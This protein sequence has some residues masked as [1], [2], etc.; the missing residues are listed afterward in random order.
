M[1]DTTHISDFETTAS[2]GETER[3]L[4]LVALENFHSKSKLKFFIRKQNPSCSKPEGSASYVTGLWLRM[5]AV[6]WPLRWDCM[7][8]VSLSHL[9]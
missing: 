8:P 5:S 4:T 1:T 2:G 6:D 9:R 3:E 7:Q